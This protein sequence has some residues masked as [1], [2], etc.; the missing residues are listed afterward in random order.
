V[1]LKHWITQEDIE[2]KTS[3]ELKEFLAFCNPSMLK[4]YKA[5]LLILKPNIGVS[6]SGECVKLF[7][8]EMR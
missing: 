2:I 4:N 8:K 1:I 5:Q 7:K 3:K 6:G